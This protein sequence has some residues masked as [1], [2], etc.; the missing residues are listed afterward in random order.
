MPPSSDSQPDPASAFR[1]PLFR[2]AALARR[3]QTEDLDRLSRVTAP[4][5]WAVLLVLAV[6]LVL[7]LIWAIFGRIERSVTTECVLVEAGDLHPVLV[8]TEGSVAEVL[9]EVGEKVRL[10]DP[11][12]RL[13]LA[14]LEAQAAAARALIAVLESDPEPN[15]ASLR[16]ARSELTALEAVLESNLHINSPSSGRVVWIDLARAERV[17]PGDEVA[18]VRAGTGGVRAYSF[19]APDVADRLSGGMTALVQPLGALSGEPDPEARRAV[20]SEVSPVQPNPP[21]WLT[22]VGGVLASSPGAVVVLDFNEPVPLDAK[23]DP[24][25]VRITIGQDRPIGLFAH[26]MPPGQMR[27]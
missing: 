5:E 26:A 15:Q 22:Q 20:V 8:Q 18:G 7:V 25:R 11:L 21:T 2:P 1:R 27:L 6:V 3:G 24:C 10:G 16:V 14:E 13:A 12:A 9:A 19:V 23:G 17:L 4:H